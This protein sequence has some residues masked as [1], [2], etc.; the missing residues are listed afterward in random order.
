VRLNPLENYFNG[1]YNA[2]GGVHA[3]VC[4]V[5]I[6]CVGDFALWSRDAACRVS[7]QIRQIDFFCWTPP[8]TSSIVLLVRAPLSGGSVELIFVS[9][10]VR[11]VANLLTS[12][13]S[14]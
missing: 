8:L 2:L 14:T 3:L 12:L 6:W 11:C 9:S 4:G 7:T 1:V 13:F 5:A 10:R